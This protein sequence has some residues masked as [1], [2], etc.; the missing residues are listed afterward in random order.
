MTSSKTSLLHFTCAQSSGGSKTD[1]ED[2]PA[3]LP[4]LVAISQL[5]N[6]LRIASVG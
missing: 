3:F 6:E 1:N 5:L 4:P 2:C